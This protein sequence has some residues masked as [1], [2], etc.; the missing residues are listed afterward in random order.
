MLSSAEIVLIDC[1]NG[2]VN[3]DKAEQSQSVVI[4]DCINTTIKVS[5]HKV[6]IAMIQF[7]QFQH[8]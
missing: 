7:I 5:A 2:V 8:K 1:R 3:V 4:T 6:L